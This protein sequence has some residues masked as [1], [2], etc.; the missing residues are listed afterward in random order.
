MPH[1]PHLMPPRPDADGLLRCIWRQGTPSRVH[2]VELFLD[3]EI[4]SAVCERFGVASDQDR[5]DP[6]YDEKRETALQRFLGYDFVRCRPAGLDLPITRIAVGDVAPLA[7]AGGRR[8]VDE[9]TGPITS[10]QDFESYAWPD[11]TAIS[12]R[13]LEWYERS[14]PDDMCVVT[15]GLGHFAEHLSWLL[16]YET[17]CLLLADDRALL[18]AVRD[19]LIQLHEAICRVFLSF[20]RVRVVWVSDDMGYRGGTLLAPDDMRELV[21]PGHRR[22]AE[23]AH[24]AGRPYVLHSCG[25]LSAIME[26]LIRDVGIDAKHSFEDTIESVIDAKARYGDRIAILGGIDVDFL[27]RADEKQV[28]ERVRWTLE[29]CMPGGG[30]CLG[31]G[32]SIANY[33]PLANYLA[34]LDEG[35]RFVVG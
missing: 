19:R 10:W 4:K 27:C 17:L 2:H 3:P 5:S 13:S 34:M 22:L 28:R 32:N 16:G 23:I 33:V 31:S 18:R 35:R 20:R 12:T 14:L 9:H 29:R 6:F 24:R 21:L 15:G 1:A 11:G 7:R 8:Y 26:D 30:Y 25:N